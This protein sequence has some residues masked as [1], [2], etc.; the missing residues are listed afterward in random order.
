MPR[1]KTTAAV[2]LGPNLVTL[3]RPATLSLEVPRVG[4]LILDAVSRQAVSTPP[5]LRN[6]APT[7]PS[8]CIV[9][10][11]QRLRSDNTHE[12]THSCSTVPRG[13]LEV[14]EAAPRKATWLPLSSRHSE[15]LSRRT[16]QNRH[17]L[18]A[19]NR[20]SRVRV[21]VSTHAAAARSNRKWR[22]AVVLRLHSSRP[23]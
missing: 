16:P 1:V 13:L 20:S 17:T 19:S 10:D 22:H 18:S 5:L 12:T 2:H 7:R 21:V 3:R 11:E 15:F 23:A 6:Q 9:A 14:G 4:V 8:A